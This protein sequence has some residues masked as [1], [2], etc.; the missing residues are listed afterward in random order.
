M[1]HLRIID[2]NIF[3]NTEKDTMRWAERWSRHPWGR[4]AF[5]DSGTLLRWREVV[6]GPHREAMEAILKEREKGRGKPEK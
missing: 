2:S 4:Y 3:M 5:Y 1:L 6:K